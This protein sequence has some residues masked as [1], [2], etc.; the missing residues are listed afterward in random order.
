MRKNWIWG[1]SLVLIAGMAS[2]KSSQSAYRAAYEKAQEKKIEEPVA[3]DPAP[4]AEQPVVTTT[5]STT[6]VAAPVRE[7]SERISAVDGNDA[8]LKEFNVIVGSFRQ[9]LNAQSLCERL[10]KDGYPAILAQNAEGWYRVVAC[11][12]DNRPAAV[13][14]REG[15]QARYPQFT[16]AWFLINK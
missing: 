10:R 11:S 8:L 6:T 2:C 13:Q 3:A 15:L 14:A 16:D 9:R 5:P 7:Q 4:V 12:F 1:L